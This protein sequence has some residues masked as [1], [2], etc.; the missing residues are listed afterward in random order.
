MT[1]EQI[2]LV[3][4]TFNDVVPISNEAAKLF[5]TKLFEL[6]EE[7]MPL[8]KGDM[9]EQGK[10][11]MQVLAAAVNGLDKISDLVPFVEELGK[12]HLGYGVKDKDYDTVGIA[13]I[14]TL[15]QGLDSKFTPQAEEAWLVVY[16][17][18]A[19]TMKSAAAKAA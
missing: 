11:L 5:Y 13:L 9:E 19:N 6:D 1:P 16:G 3:Q 7:L 2:Q 18:L 10:K 17:L 8:F 14:W 4:A 15:R 12:R